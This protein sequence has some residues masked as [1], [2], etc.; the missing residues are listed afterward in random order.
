MLLSLRLNINAELVHHLNHC[1]LGGRGMLGVTA[2]VTAN[3]L[4]E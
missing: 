2:G 1:L 3:S 4:S